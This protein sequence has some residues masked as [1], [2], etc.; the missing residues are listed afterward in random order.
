MRIFSLLLSF[1]LISYG[2][3]AQTI[4]RT[5]L[6][7]FKVE[8]NPKDGR[9]YMVVTFGVSMS[10]CIKAVEVR[11]LEN[12]RIYIVRPNLDH[13]YVK[14]GETEEIFAD[15]PVGRAK[16]LISNKHGFK[17]E[18]TIISKTGAR[19]FRGTTNFRIEGLSDNEDDLAATTALHKP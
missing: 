19:I 5:E 8:I 15:I 12:N 18:V 4:T 11:N 6:P 9:D 1:V 10:D 3:R 17:G 14:D 7:R 13:Y 16:K 2:L